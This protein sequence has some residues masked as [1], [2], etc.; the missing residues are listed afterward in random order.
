MVAA[1]V[2]ALVETICIC[3]Q[4]VA[5]GYTLLAAAWQIGFG[6]ADLLDKRQ[7]KLI[8]ASVVLAGVTRSLKKDQEA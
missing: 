7:G 5:C 3:G 4:L 1:D 8:A 2:N 6:E